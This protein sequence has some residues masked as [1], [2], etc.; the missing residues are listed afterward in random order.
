M[1]RAVSCAGGKDGG[2]CDRV[3]R[4]ESGHQAHGG[5]SWVARSVPVYELRTGKRP[6][7]VAVVGS[8]PA[9]RDARQASNRANGDPAGGVV[10]ARGGC[11]RRARR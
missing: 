5:G 3:V 8:A 2:R 9:A 11:E 10:A 6:P 1:A 4:C 7:S